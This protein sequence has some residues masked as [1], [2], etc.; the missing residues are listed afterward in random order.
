MDKIDQYLLEISNLPINELVEKI[1]QI[2]QIKNIAQVRN[3]D[4]I[5]N[6]LNYINNIIEENNLVNRTSK[7]DQ[8]DFITAINLSKNYIQSFNRFESKISN[9]SQRQKIRETLQDINVTNNVQNNSVLQVTNKT[10]KVQLQEFIHNLNIL[11]VSW[12]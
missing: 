8:K 6:N 4:Q 9:I 10:Q 1:N 12:K 3:V 7:I 11:N 5:V 2:S